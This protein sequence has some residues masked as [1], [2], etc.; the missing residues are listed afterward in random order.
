MNDLDL[1]LFLAHARVA[2]SESGDWAMDYGMDVP[3]LVSEIREARAKLGALEVWKDEALRRREA[4]RN[5]DLASQ[6]TMRVIVESG[7]VHVRTQARDFY[8]HDG[9]TVVVR[10]DGSGGVVWPEETDG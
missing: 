9:Q 8:A 10:A 7:T 2:R 6:E 3:K 4:Q 1:D 5:S